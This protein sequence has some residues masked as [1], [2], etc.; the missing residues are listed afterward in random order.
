[1]W[2]IPP[3]QAPEVRWLFFC[4][5]TLRVVTVWEHSFMPIRKEFSF[6][7]CIIVFMMRMWTYHK[8]L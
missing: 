3:G 1:M 8:H 5:E 6:G 4:Y 7:K 2:D